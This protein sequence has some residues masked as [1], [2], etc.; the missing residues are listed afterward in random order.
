MADRIVLPPPVRNRRRKEVIDGSILPFIKEWMKRKQG[1]T[2]QLPGQVCGLWYA[3]FTSRLE[4][5]GEGIEVPRIREHMKDLDLSHI[6]GW[7]RI[8]VPDYDTAC[9]IEESL[10]KNYG[11]QGE[12]SPPAETDSPCSVYV[13]YSPTTASEHAQELFKKLRQEQGVIH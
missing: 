4:I 12:N 9:E 3:G 10:H 5:T 1:I 11:M 6:E 13:Y 7:N 8:L 2:Y